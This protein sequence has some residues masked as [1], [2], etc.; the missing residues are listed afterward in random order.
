MKDNDSKIG[1]LMVMV[2]SRNLR[3]RKEFIL[4]EG[5]RLIKDAL[6]AGCSIQHL[7]FSRK[8]D[9]EYIRQLLPKKDI[10]LYKMAYRD[11]QMWS[12]LTTSPG[13]MGIFKTPNLTDISQ[14]ASSTIPL[15][16]ICDN[17]REPG[18]LGAILRASV[19]VGAEKII[20]TKG[21]VDIWEPKVL[22]SAC[23]AHFRTS[24]ETN[25]PWSKLILDVPENSAL[26]LADNNRVTA[27]NSS[28][29]NLEHLCLKVPVLPYYGVNFANY[30]SVALVIGGET[31]G[32]S[33]DAYRLAMEKQG[34]RLNIPL[35][36]DIES[37]NT[38]TA[39]GIIAFEIKR[40]LLVKK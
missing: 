6:E 3:Q 18:N 39:L 12:D 19:A 9:L 32:L 15:K 2:K 28:K 16:I 33:Q 35:N 14:K 36:N 25:M 7:M 29:N 34:V 24:I 13:I 11:I 30:S 4:V 27:D 31:M 1:T 21:C 10:R 8:S 38:G 23:G 5:K 37:L 22:R 20:L 26:F 40:Q 17:I